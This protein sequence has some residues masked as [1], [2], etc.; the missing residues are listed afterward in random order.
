MRSSPLP[1]SRSPLASP[2]TNTEAEW[3][4][5]SDVYEYGAA[6]NPEMAP[7]PVLVHPPSLHESGPTRIVPFDIDDY[8]EI[9]AQCTSP[10]LMASFLRVEIGD[11]LDTKANASSQAFYVIRGSGVTSGEHGNITW[12]EGDMF[13]V[14]V[15]EGPMKHTCVSG[16]KGGAAIYWVHDQPLM[17]YIGCKPCVK[18]FEPTLYKRADLLATVEEIKH[19]P[20]DDGSERNR[21]GVLLGNKACPQTKTLTHVLWSLLN[22]IPAKNVQRP[23]RH[24][25]V[26]LDLAVAAKPGVYTLMG[27]EIDANGNI[28]DPI[29]CDWTP[30]GV[31]VTPPGWWHSHHNESD[32]MAWVLPM[33]DAGLYT[34]QRTLDI[35]FVDDELALHRAGRIRGSAFAITNKQYTEMTIIGSQVPVPKVLGMKRVMSVDDNVKAAKRAGVDTPESSTHG[36]NQAYHLLQQTPGLTGTAGAK[37]DSQAH[38]AA[39]QLVQE[40]GSRRGSSQ[41]YHLLKVAE[42][43]MLNA[44][45]PTARAK[46]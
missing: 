33:Q 21:L 31:F 27:K 24:N 29:R 42:N 34:H 15:T 30:G 11:S 41:A 36:T 13:V 7:I 3:T 16:D 45:V 8:L 17:D 10:N 1:A 12:S 40:D 37:S 4:S 46:A 39:F 43:G 18:K 26:A 6:A 20:T 14:P 38:G 5:R 44:S 19:T 32:E 22:S 25:S 9:D 2:Q 28:V 35:R 23:H